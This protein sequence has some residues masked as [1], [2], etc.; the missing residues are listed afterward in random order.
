MIAA[1]DLRVRRLTYGGTVLDVRVF[2]R[3]CYEAAHR[4]GGKVTEFRISD[5]VTPN[6][7][8]AVI[9]YRDRTVAVACVRS[10][11]LLAIAVPRNLD[12]APVRESG[13]LNF[14]D[15]PDLAAALTE[16]GEFR[17]LTPAELNG[18]VDSAQWP[19]IT[20]DDLRIWKPTSLGEALFNYWD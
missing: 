5:E 16:V 20:S 14:V 9:A 2:R 3:V 8:Q 1:V 15:M 19:G 11:A 12:F 10:A 13:P 18:P 4:T 6:F 17:V 7:H